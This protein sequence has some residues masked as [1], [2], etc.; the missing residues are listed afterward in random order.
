MSSSPSATEDPPRAGIVVSVEAQTLDIGERE[1]REGA[2]QDSTY[3]RMHESPRSRYDG[4][5][6]RLVT[7][8]VQVR[9]PRWVYFLREKKSDFRL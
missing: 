9:I 7:Q 4:Y 3:P 1:W 2:I 6:P 5:D 8:W